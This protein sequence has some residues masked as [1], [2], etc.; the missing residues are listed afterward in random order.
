MKIKKIHL[1]FALWKSKKE[2]EPF[3][4]SP[5]SK[6]RPGW[7]IECSALSKKYLEIILIFMEEQIY[8]FRITKNELAQK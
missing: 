4:D 6:G 8:Y 2:N 1:I 7:H 5:W 3:W